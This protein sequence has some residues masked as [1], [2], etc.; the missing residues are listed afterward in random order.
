MK[1]LMLVFLSFAMSNAHAVSDVDAAAATIAA[2]AAAPAPDAPAATVAATTASAVPAVV[3]KNCKTDSEKRALLFGKEYCALIVNCKS[4]EGLAGKQN[5]YCLPDSSNSCPEG[6][7]CVKA[8]KDTLDA[9]K[10][11]LMIPK[12][13]G[14]KVA[15]IRST[16][17]EVAACAEGTPD[18]SDRANGSRR[19]PQRDNSSSPSN[20]QPSSGIK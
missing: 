13:S 2:T 9:K 14:D 6:D 4:D 5:A 7:V 11:A 8:Q 19:G 16:G 12:F 15:P 20:N 17:S 18:R 10:I 3:E 1:Y